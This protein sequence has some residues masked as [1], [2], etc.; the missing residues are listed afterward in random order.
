MITEDPNVSLQEIQTGGFCCHNARWHMRKTPNL[1]AVRL[2]G[3][4]YCSNVPVLITIITWY[5]NFTPWML[6][7]LLENRI[8]CSTRELFHSILPILH[9]VVPLNEQ[10]CRIRMLVI[11]VRYAH[12]L[13]FHTFNIGVLACGRSILPNSTYWQWNCEL[14]WQLYCCHWHQWSVESRLTD[15]CQAIKP[16]VANN[17]VISTPIHAVMLH[18]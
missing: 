12:D 8:W 10:N 11:K 6:I 5:F 13:L 7:F 3:W 1:E 4:T 9:L 14:S 18:L 15:A 17:D 16:V 2:R